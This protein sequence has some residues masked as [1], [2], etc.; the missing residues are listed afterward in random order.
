MKGWRGFRWWVWV[1]VACA[2][3]VALPGCCKRKRDDGTQ[4]EVIKEL[5]P[6]ELRDDTPNLLI[7]WIDEKGNF[8]VVRQLQEVPEHARDAVRITTMDGGHHELLY[9]ADL[10]TKKADG[11]YSVRTMA[12]SEWELIAQKRRKRT[13]IDLGPALPIP[14]NQE[15]TNPANPNPPSGV[16]PPSA[17]LAAIVYGAPWCNA[18]RMAESYLRK[19]GVHVIEKN[20]E[21]DAQARGEMQ[22]KLKQ[23]GIANKGVLP[24]VDIRGQLVVGYSTNAMDKAVR[25]A[26]QGQVL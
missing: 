5:A 3:M 1:A 24:V 20:I 8:F 13:A 18:C 26:T 17:Q 9:V 15:R 14:D 23:A 12:R 19:K 25:K 21:Q 4:P 16:V 11:T 2:V 7:T 10:R 6:L 22:L